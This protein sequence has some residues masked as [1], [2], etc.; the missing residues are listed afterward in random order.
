MPDGPRTPE[1]RERYDRAREQMA[2]IE[3]EFPG[4]KA[5]LEFMDDGEVV[6]RIAEQEAAVFVGVAHGLL[7]GQ[8]A[9]H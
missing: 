1:E 9:P 3:R 2:A 5:G 4:V 6:D 7:V 8:R